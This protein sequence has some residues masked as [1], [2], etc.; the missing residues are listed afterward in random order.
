MLL[1]VMRTSNSSDRHRSLSAK[2]SQAVSLSLSLWF[3]LSPWA[4]LFHFFF[5]PRCF[6]LLLLFPFFDAAAFPRAVSSSFLAYTPTAPVSCPRCSP[7]L[8]RVGG[9]PFPAPARPVPVAALCLAV[10]AATN[11]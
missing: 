11:T 7:V 5:F 2:T 1:D 10:V 6:F 8:R 4:C 3:L 9:F